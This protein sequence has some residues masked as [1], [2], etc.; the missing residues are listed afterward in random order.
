MRLTEEEKDIDA[1]LE[2]IRTAAAQLG[3]AL[4][5][6]DRE[7]IARVIRSIYGLGYG[8]FAGGHQNKSIERAIDRILALQPRAGG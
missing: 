5:P 4:V 2:R 7:A 3:Y 8:T 6:N 1:P